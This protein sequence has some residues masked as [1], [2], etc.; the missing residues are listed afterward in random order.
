MVAADAQN[1]KRSVTWIPRFRFYTIF[2]FTGVAL[3]VPVLDLLRYGLKGDFWWVWNS[4]RWMALHHQVLLHNPASWN[5]AQ[6]AGK[7]WADLEWAWEWFIY[8]VNPH[9]HPLVY[10]GVLFVFEVLML[11][12]FVWTMKAMAPRLTPEATWALYAL[13]SILIFPFTVRLRAELFSYVAF[14]LLLGIIWRGRTNWRWLAALV[15]VTLVWANVHGS[16][17]MIPVLMGLE[18]ARALG[19]RQWAQAG[20]NALWGIAA[21]IG[22]AGLATPL[23]FETLTYAWWLDHNHFI[24]G[25]IQEWQSVNFH[26]PTFLLFAVV[27]LAA[28]LWRVRS[29]RRYPLILDVWFI[30]TTLAF[31]DEIRM[32][33][34]F[35]MVFALWVGYGLSQN[36]RLSDLV[37]G[38]SGVA[39]FRWAAGAG[40]AAALAA[41]I[42]AGIKMGPDFLRP[43]VP[44]S[45]VAWVIRHP[46]QVVLAP[47]DDGGYLEAKGVS[48][49]FADGRSDFFLANGQRFQG[50]V[51]LVTNNPTNPRRIA[52]IF[53]DH[54]IDM[55][56]WPT[57]QMIPTLGWYLNAQKWHHAISAGGWTV[58]V[59]P[60]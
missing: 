60:R 43:V 10:V 34:Y 23:H 17:I 54:S 3:F 58:Y 53:T 29:N 4:G 28:W 42:V 44:P 15:P 39:A 2:A 49:V 41:G 47:I 14:P 9:L 27:V 32:V 45:V 26:Q 19:Q 12:T 22:V 21:P 33:T 57:S 18:A 46:H 6:L 36:P 38:S 30:G 24:S 20:Q 8:A 51:K 11:L 59:P 56:V 1:A 37:E 13:Y 7:P 35:G 5:G 25:Y 50:Y 55:V 52:A 31:F 48:R 40:M 16:W